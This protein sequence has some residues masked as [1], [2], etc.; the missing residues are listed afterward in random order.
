MKKLAVAV[1]F[2]ALALSGNAAI[3][4]FVDSV[5]QN[6][7]SN[8]YTIATFYDT[9]SM[10]L[11]NLKIV[12]F[13][14]DNS[15]LTTADAIA[16]TKAA[17]YTEAGV[18]G[19]TITDDDF[20]TNW[21]MNGFPNGPTFTNPTR[22]L[23]SAF[24]IS[25]TQTATVTYS[26]DILCSATLAGG[27]TGTMYLEYADDSGFTT[28]VVEVSRFVNGNTVSLALAITVGQTVTARVSGMIPL[29]KYVRLR[30]Q[31]NTGAPTFTFRSAQEVLNN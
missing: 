5:S 13:P 9:S 29:G 12:F 3:K 24:Q 28:N 23:N 8:M 27:Q 7:P 14:K 2:F 22:T 1:L 31:S 4:V 15:I 30:S 6:Y 16:Y 19:Y 10:S 21:A 18:K 11:V 25:T 20:I 26:V 17:V